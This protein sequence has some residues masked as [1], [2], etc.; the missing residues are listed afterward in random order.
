MRRSQLCRV[1]AIRGSLSRRPREAGSLDLLACRCALERGGEHIM[2]EQVFRK[3]HVQRQLQCGPL[4]SVAREYIGHLVGRGY[5][6]WT[7]HQYVH[8]TEHF[9]RWLASK[10]RIVAQVD[11]SSV[12]EFVT[13]HLP[14]CRCPPP[15]SK[16]V[17]VIRAALRQLLVVARGA[18]FA[19]ATGP[20]LPRDAVVADF[21][22][23]LIHSCGAAP[24]TRFYYLRETS[25]FLAAE[26]GKGA[27]DFEAIT[28]AD[29][30]AFVTKRAKVSLASV[31]Q[32]CCNRH[33]ELHPLS[34]PA[35]IRQ[36]RLDRRCAARR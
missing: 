15:S 11:S 36:R 30:R 25:D 14:R 17:H 29:V 33:P 27:V 1:G 5:A 10:D 28:P 2:I 6:G 7:V 32:L 35:R 13:R 9:G 16:T 8:A 20:R 3:A 18:D 24:A 26:F 22:R 4:A 21:E 19:V 12:D 23:H 34:P 31:R